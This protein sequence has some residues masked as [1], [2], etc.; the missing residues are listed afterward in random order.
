L[1]LD[2]TQGRR[3]NTENF[4]MRLILVDGMKQLFDGPIRVTAIEELFEGHRPL[5]ADF[6]ERR[7][8]AVP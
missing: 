7:Q 5:D 1:V 3:T 8:S 4:Q 6:T 2:L